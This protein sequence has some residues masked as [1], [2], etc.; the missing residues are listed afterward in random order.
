MQESKTKVI[1]EIAAYVLPL[2]RQDEGAHTSLVAKLQKCS[3]TQ[4]LFPLMNL[5]THKKTPLTFMLQR[6]QKST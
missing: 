4:V 5:I 1:R 6:S 2:H 3:T